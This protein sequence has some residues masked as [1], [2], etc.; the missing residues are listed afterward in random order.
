MLASTPRI[1]H[2]EHIAYGD[3]RTHS[4]RR[5]WLLSHVDDNSFRMPRLDSIAAGDRGLACTAYRDR[6]TEARLA[7]KEFPP[8]PLA[9]LPTKKVEPGQRDLSC[10][11][12]WQARILT[13]SFDH[14]CESHRINPA[15]EAASF[16][17]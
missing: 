16:G 17:I 7:V 2:R 3:W 12:I 10:A 14:H 11:E 15:L 13:T 4:A 1:D 6:T 9:L 8:R 5:Q